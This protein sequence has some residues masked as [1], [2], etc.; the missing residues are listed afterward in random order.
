MEEEKE[1][2]IPEVDEGKA[3]VELGNGFSEA[4]ELLKDEKKTEDF[5]LQLENKLK[6]VPK[7]G[8]TLAMIPILIS[9]V[10]DYIRKVYT[11]IPL[12]TIVA[13]VSALLYFLTPLDLIPDAILGAGYIDDALV[14]AACLKL[15][16]SDV[17]EYTKWRNN[18]H[19]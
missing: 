4:E 19:K 3:L 16:H 13:V 1:K 17:E 7:V 8:N 6:I 14:V 2:K 11:T 5:L 10:R 18:N 12:G 15:V 9:L